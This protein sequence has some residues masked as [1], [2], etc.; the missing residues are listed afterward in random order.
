[1][2]GDAAERLNLK[3][4]ANRDNARRVE[5]MNKENAYQLRLGLDRK[6][7]KSIKAMMRTASE[8]SLRVSSA[9]HFLD[10]NYDPSS[11]YD[12]LREGK[13]VEADKLLRYGLSGYNTARP[14]GAYAYSGI[15]QDGEGRS[16]Y[17]RYRGAMSPVQK[18][19]QPATTSQCVGWGAENFHYK[20]SKY[21]R[22]PIIAKNFYRSMNVFW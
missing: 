6:L 11:P 7:P 18:F 16:G 4:D 21:S 5:I 9:Q 19:E 15:N 3:D 8:P 12:A 2:G 1:M 13:P 10:T 14:M 20:L 17:L 22:K